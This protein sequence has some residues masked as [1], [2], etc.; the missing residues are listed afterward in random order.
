MAQPEPAPGPQT[1]PAPQKPAAPPSET[2]A[3]HD[4]V[5][6]S[7]FSSDASR[8][9]EVRAVST[10]TDGNVIAIHVRTGGFLGFG[11]RI[12]AVPEGKFSRG[13]QSLKLNLSAKQVGKLPEIKDGN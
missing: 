6:L 10:G 4:L 1:A 7:V 3:G 13:G 11:S 5:G 8:V 2:P 12:V 9:G